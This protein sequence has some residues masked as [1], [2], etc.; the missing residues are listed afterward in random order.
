MLDDNKV[1]TLWLDAVVHNLI[2]ILASKDLNKVVKLGLSPQLLSLKTNLKDGEHC[3]GKRVKIWSGCSKLKVK[4]SAKKLHPKQCKNE[5]EEKEEE[6]QG[7]N[8][9]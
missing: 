4:C 1:D 7:D 2:P 3:N 6:E 9:F 5:N 8:R